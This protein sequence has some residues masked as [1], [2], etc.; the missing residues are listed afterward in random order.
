MTALQQSLKGGSAAPA[1]KS[2]KPAKRASGQKE[3]LL[4][5]SG[6]REGT[7]EDKKVG[8]KPVRQAGKSARKAG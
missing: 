8:T 7:R 1:A 3:M 2:K 4:P 6:K 5:I